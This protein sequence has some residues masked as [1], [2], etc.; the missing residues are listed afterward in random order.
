MEN[1]LNGFKGDTDRG[2]PSWFQRS[3]RWRMPF[4]VSEKLDGGCPF[5]LEYKYKYYM[6]RS[7]IETKY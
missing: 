1:T 6:K 2:C 4:L 5:W 3:Y 7:L